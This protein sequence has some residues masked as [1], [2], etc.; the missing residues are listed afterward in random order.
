[1]RPHRW[2]HNEFALR[3]AGVRLADARADGARVL[4]ARWRGLHARR[5][6]LSAGEWGRAGVRRRRAGALARRLLPRRQAKPPV[7]KGHM[8]GGTML[9]DRLFAMACGSVLAV[10]SFVAG[11]RVGLALGAE[12]EADVQ[13]LLRA[14]G[15][16]Q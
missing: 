12:E 7:R 9:Q 1:S 11:L 15:A 2:E 5:P 6:T 14:D 8:N 10:A 3:R 16:L 13:V 4:E